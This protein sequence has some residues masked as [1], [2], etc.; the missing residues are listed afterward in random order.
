MSLFSFLQPK[1]DPLVPR[2]SSNP[3]GETLQTFFEMRRTLNYHLKPIIK[4]TINESGHINGVILNE[5]LFRCMK[6]FDDTNRYTESGHL[7]RQGPIAFIV[8]TSKGHSSLIVSCG[9]NIYGIGIVMSQETPVIVKPSL[10]DFAAKKIANI[11][12]PK[13]EF[14]VD[15]TSP[16]AAFDIASQQ[17]SSKGI[18]YA[19]CTIK[20][21]LP[22]KEENA[23]RLLTFLNQKNDNPYELPWDIECNPNSVELHTNI[24]YQTVN[25]PLTTDLRVN[26]HKITKMNCANLMELMFDELSGSAYAGLASI[27]ESITDTSGKSQDITG[28]WSL[29]QPIS[30]S[31]VSSRSNSAASS[32]RGSPRSERG[33]SSSRSPRSSSRSRSRDRE[34]VSLTPRTTERRNIADERY[35][36]HVTRGDYR[37]RRGDSRGINKTKK[38][39]KTRKERERIQTKEREKIKKRRTIRRRKP[40]RSTN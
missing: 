21:I 37:D 18:S 13:F 8:A 27:P 32:P 15:V 33:R 1:N 26:P 7:I 11:E 19:A 36:L 14:T 2:I 23:A 24:E 28:L 40:R 35:R 12:P 39:R 4:C 25:R 29:S 6:Q 5:E 20:A 30:L 16:D 38:E 22:F 17:R 9:S 10:F 31:P 34:I 3:I